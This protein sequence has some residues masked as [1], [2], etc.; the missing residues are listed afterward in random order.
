MI[1][2]KMIHVEQAS[3]VFECENADNGPGSLLSKV[4]VMN[5]KFRTYR[6]LKV[7]SH[8]SFEVCVLLIQKELFENINI[9]L[10]KNGC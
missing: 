7:N 3:G 4:I 10:F 6:I 1:L 8:D 5:V 2:S 9:C